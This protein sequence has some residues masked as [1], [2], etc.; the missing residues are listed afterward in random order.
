MSIKYGVFTWDF[1][2]SLHQ[3]LYLSSGNVTHPAQLGGPGDIDV[4][5]HCG[6]DTTD[7]G[8]VYRPARA[9]RLYAR[10][11]CWNG[12]LQGKHCEAVNSNRNISVYAGEILFSTVYTA[13]I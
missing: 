5:R 4:I 7:V 1:T 8:D 3:H 10:L 12:I 13:L 11:V 6:R 2:V 9:L